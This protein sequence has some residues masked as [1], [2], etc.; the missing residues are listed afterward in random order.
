MTYKSGVYQHQT[1]GMLGGHAVKI[2]GYGVEDG[3]KY[4][5]L[6]N[7]WNESWGDKGFFKILRGVGHCGV[8]GNNVAGLPKILM[9]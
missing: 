4:W 5:L 2:I 6:A 9:N 8:E 7:S 3:V 1:G